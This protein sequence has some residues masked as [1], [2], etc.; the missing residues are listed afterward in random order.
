MPARPSSGKQ[1]PRTAQLLTA[2][3]A[4]RELGVKPETL[5]SYVSRGLLHSQAGE[6]P[7]SRYY[8]GKEVAALKQR[9]T[10]R[11]HPGQVAR[12]TLDWGTPVLDSSITLIDDG[13]LF[14]RGR[15]V[16]QLAR[17][18]SF[19]EVAALL[20][21]LEMAAVDQL[22][23]QVHLAIAASHRRVLARAG[24]GHPS[25]R[26]HLLLR[27]LAY[28]D[29]A[30]AE[31]KPASVARC[32]A[33][34]LTRLAA[35]AAGITRRTRGS[36]AEVLAQGWDRPS[37]APAIN[38]AL[39]LCADHELNVSSFTAR[40][41]ASAGAT[42]YDVVDAGLCALRGFRHGG[43]TD[44]VEA[45]LLE[46]GVGDHGPVLGAAQARR[47]LGH[48][49]RRGDRI[50]GLGQ[51]LYP[52]GDPR[53][54]LLMEILEETLP[55]SRV[56]ASARVVAEQAAELLGERPTVDFA[57]ATASAALGQ[58]PGGGF[59][60]FA[61]GRIAGW[62]AHALEEYQRGS[63]IRPRARYVGPPPVD[64]DPGIG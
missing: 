60:L 1:R 28:D 15:N 16:I 7:R 40:C 54:A 55:D 24:E 11:R 57:L 46:M 32:G 38:A 34:L 5:Y 37:A 59:T 19:E 26:F 4:A 49:L 13:S 18:A 23:D 47:L 61:L 30:A 42:P 45:L 48:R 3:E 36:L 43:H 8:L 53:F 63:L 33:R 6:D 2:R 27:L 9:R 51:P 50:P 12:G 56:V 35:L 17:E 10:E 64:L 44:R 52:A 62:I 29:L 21:G 41:V 58:V 39:V 20:W 14:Y 22:F 25:D 31:L